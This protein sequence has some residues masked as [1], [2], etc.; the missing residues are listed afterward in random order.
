MTDAPRAVAVSV[1]KGGVGKST[2]AINLARELA[3]RGHR[4]LLSD[5]DPNGHATV[6]LGFEDAYHADQDLGDVLFEGEPPTSLIRPTDYQLD[7]L[8]SNEDLE[9]REREFTT[10]DL[11]RPSTQ[12]REKI[13]EPLIGDHYD[14]IVFDTPAYRGKLSD[15]ALAAAQNMLIPIAPGNEAAT[16]LQR[17]R[18]RHIEPL[19]EH[20]DLEILAVVPN[21]LQA[22]IDQ[23]TKDRELLEAM[24]RHDEL[25][26]SIPDFARITPE[27]FEA[28]D[29]GEVPPPKPGIRY[30]DAFTRAMGEHK[31]L[32]D[33]DPEND[34]LQH[35]AELADIVETT[36]V[37]YDV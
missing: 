15:N 33:Y 1:L 25:A 19:R 29:A 27:E 20:L 14:Y 24:N 8:P 35:F 10:R 32:M 30:R 28:I 2:T 22:R 34:Q 3:N 5:L 7:I 16:G 17:T 13:V 23:Q 36:G 9:S 21:K 4:T 18:E 6:G 31:P 11:F 12:I 26:D 37:S